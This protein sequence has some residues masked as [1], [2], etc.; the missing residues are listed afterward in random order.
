[1]RKPLKINNLTE[2]K[3][4]IARLN[5]LKFEQE[6]YLKDQYH[7]LNRKIEAPVRFFRSITSRIPGVDIVSQLF[8]SSGN[9][10]G[11]EDGEGS[12]WATKALRI[13]VPFLLNKF[14][15][16]RAGWLKKALVLLASETAIGQVNKD[17]ISSA[18]SKLSDYIRPGKKKE[19]KIKPVIEEDA[20]HFGI[21]PDSETY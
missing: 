9:N 5:E 7:L 14:F 18:I 2:L 12:G 4:E 10:K 16:K 17:K 19:K 21:P 11:T 3:A 15:L 20:P 13:G 6:A 8:S 1:M